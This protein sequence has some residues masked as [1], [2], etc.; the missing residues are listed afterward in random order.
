MIL[1]SFEI[2]IASDH[3]FLLFVA[4]NPELLTPCSLLF[5]SVRQS[6]RNII[7]YCVVWSFVGRDM[8]VRSHLNEQ[9][10]TFQAGSLLIACLP[11]AIAAQND[12]T[13]S[14]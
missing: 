2:K 11:K 12:K 4:H 6:L 10:T 1:T 13:P 3:S 5:L 8:S 9:L 7:S 14:T